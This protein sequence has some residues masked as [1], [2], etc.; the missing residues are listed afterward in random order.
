MIRFVRACVSGEYKNFV[1]TNIVLA[2]SALLYFISPIDAIPD[3]I[4]TF[5]FLDDMVIIAFV[6][7]I[8]KEELDAFGDWEQEQEN[9]QEKE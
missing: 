1:K 4:P 6:Y 3:I 2:V 5:G 9:L 7:N 8:I